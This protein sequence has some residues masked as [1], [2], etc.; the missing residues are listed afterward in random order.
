MTLLASIRGARPPD[1][2]AP[3]TRPGR[4]SG[5]APAELPG[6][7]HRDTAATTAPAHPFD[8]LAAGYDS[9]FSE[10]TLGRWLRRRVW[11][12]LDQFLPREGSFID[13]GCGTGEDAL[14]LAGRG[15]RV[16]AVDA[17]RAMLERARAKAAARGLAGRVELVHA[18]LA[19]AAARAEALRGPTFDGAL[20]DFGAINCA[21]V[22]VSLFTALADALRPGARLVV[23]AMGP[24]CAWE[25][26]TALVTGRFRMAF[27][28]ARSGAQ[29]ALG[30]GAGLPVWYP[31]PGRLRS[32]CA[33]PFRRLH[34][35]PLGLL[36]PTTRYAGL[37]ERHPR[38]FGRLERMERGLARFGAAAWLA[39]HHLGVFERR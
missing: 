34:L 11:D 17:S 1:H 2:E 9:G 19:D 21:P 18:D 8:V 28:R 16:R 37:V 6:G 15:A 3:G 35:E 14:W 38:L 36:L 20:S 13:L 33:G 30:D 12:R 10:R 25:T 22:R 29:A 23:V 27:R 32:E 26:A 24:F 4:R 7:P 39:D 31:S 5:D